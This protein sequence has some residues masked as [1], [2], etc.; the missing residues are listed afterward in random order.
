MAS[1]LV[2]DD[3]GVREPS[4]GRDLAKDLCKQLRVAVLEDYLLDRV[5][6]A[7]QLVLGPVQD[8]I[9]SR[10]GIRESVLADIE[11]SF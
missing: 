9:G 7:V 3:V 4:E 8:E 5:L 2:A 10:E 6:A 1:S 11:T